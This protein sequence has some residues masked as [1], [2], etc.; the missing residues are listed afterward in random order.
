MRGKC[1]LKRAEKRRKRTNEKTGGEEDAET[2][3]AVVRGEKRRDE[4][5]RG[6]G[7]GAVS[8][9]P[10]RQRHL[11]KVSHAVEPTEPCTLVS[12]SLS[13]THTTIHKHPPSSSPSPP[14]PSSPPLSHSDEP[15]RAVI[16]HRARASLWRQHA[17]SHKPCVKTYF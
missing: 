8:G 12:P 9:S 14:P 5:G 1:G 15:L 4:E 13:P 17:P 7:G 3:R 11:V 2:S 16:F 6:E 10:V